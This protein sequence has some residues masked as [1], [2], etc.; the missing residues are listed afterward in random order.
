MSVDTE[1]QGIELGTTPTTLPPMETW[2][3]WPALPDMQSAE[4]L[5]PEEQRDK[6][7]SGTLELLADE[8]KL[9]EFLALGGEIAISLNGELSVTDPLALNY[10]PS[11]RGENACL[12]EAPDNSKAEKSSYQ[13]KLYTIDYLGLVKALKDNARQ[14]AARDFGDPSDPTLPVSTEQRAEI[15]QTIDDVTNEFMYKNFD[16]QLAVFLLSASLTGDIVLQMNPTD[17]A[18]AIRQEFMWLDQVREKLGYAHNIDKV[19][20]VLVPSKKPL[21][22]LSV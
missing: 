14:M 8:E 18:T 22:R 20:I 10:I 21:E 1:T 3:I 13:R 16:E 19:K 4:T 12:A 5:S 11:P 2:E 6:L 7:R 17:T 9:K 15:A